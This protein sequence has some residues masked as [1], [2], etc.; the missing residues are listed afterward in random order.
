MLLYV[1]IP[2]RVCSIKTNYKNNAHVEIKWCFFEI[3]EP[4]LILN[5]DKTYF[6]RKLRLSFTPKKAYQTQI[7]AV[8]K[9]YTVIICRHIHIAYKPKEK[10]SKMDRGPLQTSAT[11]Q[12][13]VELKML[14]VKAGAMPPGV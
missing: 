7:Q 9:D 6:S 4:T 2:F 1:S 12:G 8:G 11:L 10:K 3:P 13:S 14:S 5:E